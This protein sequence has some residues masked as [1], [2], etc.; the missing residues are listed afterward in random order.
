MKPYCFDHYFEYNEL[1]AMLNDLRA[2]YPSLIKIHSICTTPENR[3]VWACEITNYETGDILSKPAYYVDGNHHAGEVTGSMVA[4][5]FIYSLVTKYRTDGTIK[6]LLDANSVYAIPRISPDG[7]ETYLT[8]AEKLRSVNRPY[9]F[10]KPAPGLHAK[11][12]DGDGVIR[13]MRVESPNGAWKESKK[14][15]RIMTKRQPSDF[16]GKYY[17]CYPEGYIVDYDGINIQLAPNKWGLDFN[18]NYPMGWFTEVRQPGAGAYPLSNPETKAVADFVIS[19]PNICSAVTYHTSGGC[20]IYPP[21]TM[22]E[23]KADQRDM[24]MFKEIGAMATEETSYGCFNI[25][26]AFLTDTV[27]YSSGAFDDWMYST[28]GIPTYTAEMWD[29]AI[30][31]GVPNVYPR[32]V[33]LTAAQQEEQE[34]LCYKWIDEHVPTVKSGAPFK[35]W[36]KFEH[37]Q[38]GKVEIGGVDFKYTWQNCPPGYLEAEVEKNVA[39]CVRMACTM[40]KLKIDSLVSEKAGEGVYKVTAVVSNVGYLPTFVCNEAKRLK[41]DKELV[42]KADTDGE[43]II[44]KSVR[45]FGHLEGFSG[46]NAGYV[47]GGVNT[48][49]HDPFTKKTEYV[50]KAKEG[51][52]FTLTV[53]GVKAGSVCRTIK[54]S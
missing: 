49:K 36:T 26:D 12:M 8:S 34:Y 15:P 24:R 27:N 17:N 35:R 5:Y 16:G 44:G 45:S 38:L 52:E 28:Q 25:F 39:F 53:S 40:P 47:Q 23:A 50:V 51:S 1:T 11:D 21:G 48:F 32:T 6:A 19:H 41:V 30:R 2:E 22:P 4:A 37:P 7:A 33:P 54:L 18:R 14:D 10:E 31:A 43:I 29:L 13:I 20:Y 42:I 46:I 9:P 3:E